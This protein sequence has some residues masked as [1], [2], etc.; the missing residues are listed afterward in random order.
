MIS[1]GA[2]EGTPLTHCS[3]R[4]GRAAYRSKGGRM[5]A[6]SQSGLAQLRRWAGSSTQL[7]SR[8]QLSARPG[9]CG[10]SLGTKISLNLIRATSP[11]P[12][13]AYGKK[14]IRLIGSSLPER[15]C[16]MI[17]CRVCNRKREGVE[18]SPGAISSI[19]AECWGKPRGSARKPAVKPLAKGGEKPAK[20][21]KAAGVVPK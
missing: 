3:L 5:P 6:V 9:R 16:S 4:Q 12:L 21:R 13:G 14:P 19:C 17:N 8:R 11:P 2:K 18:L 15:R 10:L 1:G 7:P 20:K